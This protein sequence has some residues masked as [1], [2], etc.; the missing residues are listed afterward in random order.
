MVDLA[1]LSLVVL[2]GSKLAW[3]IYQ[4]AATTAGAAGDL[5]A[6]AGSVS[7]LCL[8]LQHLAAAVKEDD[9]LPSAEVS[10]PCTNFTFRSGKLTD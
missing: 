6:V 3:S 1:A 4:F 10:P 8:T 2:R 5:H 7:D 9:T